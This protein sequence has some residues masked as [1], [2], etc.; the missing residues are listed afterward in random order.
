MRTLFAHLKAIALSTTLIF[1]LSSEV[2]ASLEGRKMQ[3]ATKITAMK[4]A[5]VNPT[6]DGEMGTLNDLFANQTGN[7]PIS[8]GIGGTA[9]PTTRY[10]LVMV[11][12]TGEDPSPNVELTGREGRRVV[13]RKIARTYDPT[14]RAFS[15]VGEP[16]KTYVYFFI[17]GDRCATIR[18]TARIVGQ[19]QPSTVVRTINFICGE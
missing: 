5:T 12:T 2:A 18:L 11:E 14:G 13:Y 6:D 10:L 9:S 8:H 4:V 16:I 7:A 17:E 3:A 1:C 19:R 15:S